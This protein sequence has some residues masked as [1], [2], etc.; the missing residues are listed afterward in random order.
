MQITLLGLELHYTTQQGPSELNKGT[1]HIS[2]LIA[3]FPLI[4]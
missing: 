2:Y 4:Y 1:A 3:H